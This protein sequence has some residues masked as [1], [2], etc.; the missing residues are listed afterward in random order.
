M[1][2]WKGEEVAVK[3]AALTAALL[4]FLKVGL[5]GQLMAVPTVV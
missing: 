3:M 5:L 4:G 1:E 2:V